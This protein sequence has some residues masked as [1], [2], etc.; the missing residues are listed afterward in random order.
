MSMEA[1]NGFGS[2]V[3]CVFVAVVCAGAVWQE[4]QE[5]VGVVVPG[6]VRAVWYWGGRLE[7]VL[8]ICSCI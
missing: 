5:E 6:F 2:V 1:A 3:L 4:W 7:E 8:C